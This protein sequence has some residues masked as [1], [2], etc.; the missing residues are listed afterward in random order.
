MET[1]I[2]AKCLT[3]DG[4]AWQE[5]YSRYRKSLLDSIHKQLGV[6][7]SNTDLVEEIAAR[8]WYSLVCRDYR[9][10]R[11]YEKGRAGFKTYLASLARQQVRLYYREKQRQRR[12]EVPLADSDNGCG[13]C[14][15]WPPAATQE[16]FIATLSRREKQ[17]FEQHLLGNAVETESASLSVANRWKLRQRVFDKLK[18]FLEMG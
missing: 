10:L 2:I 18:A 3:G 7:A 1:V 15:D 12:R 11:A 14:A 4:A 17:Y 6:K 9:R 16:E 5:F 8:V 13:G